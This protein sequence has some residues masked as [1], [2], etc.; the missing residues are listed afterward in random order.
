MSVIDAD[1]LDDAR[2]Q[3]YTAKS[4]LADLPPGPPVANGSTGRMIV[5]EKIKPTN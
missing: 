3:P 5:A 2:L 1:W 4:A